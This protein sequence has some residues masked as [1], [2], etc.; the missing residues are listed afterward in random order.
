[1]QNQDDDTTKE[2][3]RDAKTTADEAEETLDEAGDKIKVGAKAVGNNLKD[4]DRDLDTEYD[5]EK[6]NE[7]LT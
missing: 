4:L 7:D 2:I 5:K 6:I 1:M 3:V